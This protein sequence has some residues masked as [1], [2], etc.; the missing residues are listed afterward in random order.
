M[1]F[2]IVYKIT[3]FSGLTHEQN[4]KYS[5]VKL[6]FITTKS[7]QMN[8]GGKHDVCLVFNFTHIQCD[9]VLCKIGKKLSYCTILSLAISLQTIKNQ[10]FNLLSGKPVKRIYKIIIR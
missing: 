8:K 6:Q 2:I 10:L 9:H 4:K 5:G 1:I 3:I 7:Y